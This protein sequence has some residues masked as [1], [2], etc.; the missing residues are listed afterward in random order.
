ME[1]KEFT[2]GPLIA[3]CL[4]RE[5]AVEGWIDLMGPEDCCV[6]R[7]KAP[8][9]LRALYGDDNGNIVQNAVHGSKCADDAIH[10][11]RLFFPNS[12]NV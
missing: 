9:T 7:V 3:L 8:T 11:L 12:K 5:N 1:I 6:A 4:A 10:E 2:S